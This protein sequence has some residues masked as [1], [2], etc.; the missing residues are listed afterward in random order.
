MIASR[1]LRW[2]SSSPHR[3]SPAGSASRRCCPS[4]RPRGSSSAV[5]LNTAARAIWSACARVKRAASAPVRSGARTGRRAPARPARRR[6]RRTRSPDRGRRPSRA[7]PAPPGR[8]RAWSRSWRRRS[9]P[10]RGRAGRAA[11]DLVVRARREQRHDRVV[12]RVVRAGEDPRQRL[13]A[14]DQP[15][16]DPV[17]Q[18]AGRHPRERDQQQPLERRPLGHVA[19]GQRRRSCTSCRCP[20]SPRAR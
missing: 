9:R 4:A 1:R 13:L 6:P 18:L 16:P 14:T 8:S 5:G 20:R 7:R 2:S 11:L 17:A 12:A 10:R 3:A 19:R 15:L